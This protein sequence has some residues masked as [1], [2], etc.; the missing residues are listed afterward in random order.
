MLAGT[1][2]E[3]RVKLPHR[4]LK[5]FAEVQVV[6]AAMAPRVELAPVEARRFLQSLRR[7]QGRGQTWA[8]PTGRGLRLTTRPSS[9]A[10]CVSGPERLHFLNAM[11]R[12]CRGLTVY[13][14]PVSD[15]RL[16]TSSAW[17]LMLDDAALVVV[18]SLNP[19]T[20]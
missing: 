9:G 13:G 16:P 11:S 8:V 2:V 18:L 7:S 15:G 6:A 10:V 3:H 14:L 19:W 4:W 12:Y 1:A 17:Q 20:G 5:G